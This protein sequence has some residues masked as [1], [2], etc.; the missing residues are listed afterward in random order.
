MPAG[1]VKWFNATT[2]F[3]LHNRRTV[4][5]ETLSSIS[6]QSNGRG[7]PGLF[8]GQRVQYERE[9]DARGRSAVTNLTIID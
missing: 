1:T 3:R 2:G 7:L 4:E 8:E 9:A 5:K 6:L